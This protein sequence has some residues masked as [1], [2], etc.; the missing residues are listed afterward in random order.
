MQNHGPVLAIGIALLLSASCLAQPGDI[1]RINPEDSNQAVRQAR[2]LDAH[3]EQHSWGDAAELLQQMIEAYPHQ[4]IPVHDEKP[5]RYISIRSYCHSRIAQLPD[6]ALAIYRQRVDSQANSLWTQFEQTNEESLLLRLVDEYLCSSVGDQALERIGDRAL[7]NGR[8]DEAIGWW[9]I[10]LPSLDPSNDGTTPVAADADATMAAEGVI[11]Y[12]DPKINIARLMAKWSIAHLIRGDLDSARKGVAA[13]K[14]SYP[15]AE[16]DL[17][18]RAGRYWQTLESAFGDANL[19][20][21]ARMSA[22]WPTFAGRFERTKTAPAPLRLGSIARRWSLDPPVANEDPSTEE[23]DPRFPQFG[24]PRRP[25]KR[26]GLVCH[27][28][29]S[30]PYVFASDGARLHKFHVDQ[31]EPVAPPFIFHDMEKSSGAAQ[32]RHTLSLHGNYLFARTGTTEV[33]AQ[34]PFPGRVLA[35]ESHLYCFDPVNWRLLWWKKAAD[36]GLGDN[37]VFEGAPVVLGHQVLVGVT[38]VDAMSTSYIVCLDAQSSSGEVLWTRLVCEASNEHD[39]AVNPDQNLLTLADRTVYCC[40]NTGA[41]A[42][43][44]VPTAKIRWI[45]EYALEASA[46]VKSNSPD[47]N[48]CVYERGRLFV[49]PSGSANVLCLDAR[50]G[51]LLWQTRV[52]TSYLLGVAKDRL[53][54]AGTRLSALDVTTGRVDWTFPENNPGSVGR[55]LLAGNDVYWPTASEVHVLDQATGA[56][57]QAAISLLEGLRLKP[58]NW[59]AGDG[60]ALLAQNRQ[61]VVLRPSR[62]LKEQSI[63]MVR[64]SPESA[65]AHF[66]LADAAA[67]DGDYSLALSHFGKAIQYA[68]PD[69]ILNG[70]RLVNQAKKKLFETRLEAARVKADQAMKD[71]G[72]SRSSLLTEAEQLYRDAVR[73]AVAPLQRFEAL[74]KCAELKTATGEFARALALY[75][76]ILADRQAA[77][78][79]ADAGTGRRRRAQEI[80]EVAINDLLKTQGRSLYAPWET[81]LSA[82]LSAAKDVEAILDTVE[83][84]PFATTAAGQLIR[85]GEEFLQTGDETSAIRAFALAARKSD[86]PLAK[87]TQ[88]RIQTILDPDDR[89]ASAGTLIPG[90]SRLDQQ[91]DPPLASVEWTTQ[92]LHSEFPSVAASW[93][94]AT[95]EWFLEVDGHKI[96]SRSAK[97]GMPNW[98]SDLAFQAEWFSASAP[99]LICCARDQVCCLDYKYGGLVWTTTIED[100]A[101]PWQNAPSISGGSN[102]PDESAGECPAYAADWDTAFVVTKSGRLVVLDLVRGAVREEIDPLAQ[103]PDSGDGEQLLPHVQRIGSTLLLWTKK[104]LLGLAIDEGR[105]AWTAP[106]RHETSGFAA[107]AC[108][109]T[110][111][112]GMSADAIAVALARDEI[113]CI[114]SKSGKVLWRT[115]LGWP[116]WDVPRLLPASPRATT[117]AVFVIVDGYAL[118]RLNVDSG[119]VEWMVA[120][121]HSPRADFLRE[122]RISEDRVWLAMDDVLECRSLSDGKPLWRQETGASDGCLG[123][124]IYWGLVTDAATQRLKAWNLQDGSIARDAELETFG[125]EMCFISRAG[126]PVILRRDQ[127]LALD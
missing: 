66:Q 87:E 37:A 2:L 127:A 92:T 94:G 73:D 95:D 78:S 22:D 68:G 107:V 5:A 79:L 125:H 48:P 10:L 105:V 28:V 123:D 65:E 112:D 117:R 7:A 53:F 49:S 26:D 58:G 63:E 88:R 75:Q 85:A 110:T 86:E 93:N 35:A 64:Q 25:R 113:T 38:R 4:V 101:A 104:R 40:T 83:R 111:A 51:R 12:P 62:W 98:T 46:S 55:G 119:L 36:L 57:T 34:Q 91:S 118:S 122:S 15:E 24:Q 17:A 42:A 114:E 76:E 43:L 41:I 72:A 44:D 106:I 108:R 82:K 45:R 23:F 100:S 3:L 126:P 61:I 59:I 121:T 29:T 21:S 96:A 103:C 9:N 115:M 27:P 39:R 32:E 6:D 74:R 56:R 11:H 30:G 13:L 99:G 67:D 50:S 33:I 124:G 77:N 8:M 71:P 81:E 60:Y 89:A 47:L 54:V 70:H 14:E 1:S 19:L 20:A 52:G 16:G 84:Y 18:G 69:R 109:P 97:T 90:L 120:L 116:S 31:D 80:V 102:S